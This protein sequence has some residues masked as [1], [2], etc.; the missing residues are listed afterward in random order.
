MKEPQAKDVMTEG[1]VAIDEN[2]SVKE[3]AKKMREEGI[4][5][6][7]VVSDREVVGIVVDRDITYKVTAEGKN[8]SDVQIKDIM[9]SDLVTASESD[10]IEDIARAMVKNN[11]SRVPV[12][13]GDKLLGLISQSNV[14]R[15]WP[16]YVDLL[17][18]EVRWESSKSEIYSDKS[19]SEGT[20]DSC[21][22]YSDSLVEVEGKML[23]EQCRNL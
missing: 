15:A 12:L 19:S 6:I 11:I 3:A 22:N 9:T 14:L 23:C 13:R 8:P 10:N 7:I 17:E 18:E 4:R 2:A 20:C 1:V 21:G 16:A 5:S